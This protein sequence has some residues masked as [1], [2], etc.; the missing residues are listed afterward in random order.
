[1]AWHTSARDRP[2]ERGH[3]KRWKRGTFCSRTTMDRGV[4]PPTFLNDRNHHIFGSIS[5]C[6][7]GLDNTQS[8][9]VTVKVDGPFLHSSGASSAPGRPGKDRKDAALARYAMA[10]LVT[11]ALREQLPINSRGPAHSDA[12]QPKLLRVG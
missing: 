8:L 4:L 3:L 9:P 5:S 2:R 12:A 6:G 11:I 1:M 10:F 7:G